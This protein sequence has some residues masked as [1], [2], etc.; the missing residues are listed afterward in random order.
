MSKPI[1]L[2]DDMI[3]GLLTE[4]R[5]WLSGI[6]SCGKISFEKTIAGAKD[7]VVL[8]FTPNAY[9]KM[10]LLVA[11]YDTEAAWHGVVKRHGD[12]FLVTDVLVYP[13]EVTGSTVN[14]DQTKYQDW[15]FDLDDEQFNNLR[16]HGHSHVNM[17][18]SPSPVDM[19]H[20]KQL[21]E[22]VPEDEFYVFIIINKKNEYTCAIYD[23]A[24][25]TMF[26]T[27]DTEIK[28]LGDDDSGFLTLINDAKD[29]IT[30]KAASYAYG[31]SP[32]GYGSTYGGYYGQTQQPV[33]NGTKAVQAASAAVSP[34]KK[35][36]RIDGHSAYEW[37]DYDDYL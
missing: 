19:E 16:F 21:I 6:R 7:K 23:F 14:T 15:L 10:K 33:S 4:F 3:S 31:D 35:G 34:K 13:Q 37:D 11:I 1:K 26:E 20:R 22:Q 8:Y 5:T 12:D 27:A 30:K 18:T 9:A 29:K 24:R 32:Y 28:I 17:G 25:N 2:N 36:R